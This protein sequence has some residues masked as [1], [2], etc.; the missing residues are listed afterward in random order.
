MQIP[1]I[2]NPSL[3]LFLANSLSYMAILLNT[4][5]MYILLLESAFYQFVHV[6]ILTAA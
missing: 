3:N 1:E 2:L 4:L 6:K 5:F